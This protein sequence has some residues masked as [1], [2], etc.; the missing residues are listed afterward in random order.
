VLK[1]PLY[2]LI[3]NKFSSSLENVILG[4]LKSFFQL[5]QQVDITFDFTKATKLCQSVELASFQPS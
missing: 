2:N 4:N 1:C 5:S 3:R